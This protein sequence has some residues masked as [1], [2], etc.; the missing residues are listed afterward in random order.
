MW[1]KINTSVH[2]YLSSKEIMY[3]NLQLLEKSFMYVTS[4]L[5]RSLLNC[6]EAFCK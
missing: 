6:S 5:A 1:R 4:V 2:D 3:L